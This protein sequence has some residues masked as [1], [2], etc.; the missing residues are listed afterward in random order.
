L[1]FGKYKHLCSPKFIVCQKPTASNEIAA[2]I[3]AINPK[4]SDVDKG[5]IEGI[6]PLFDITVPL[7]DVT[8]PLIDVTVP[9]IDVTVP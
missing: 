6:V 4:N 2:I 1:F 7:N 9:L 5:R 8:V 3:P